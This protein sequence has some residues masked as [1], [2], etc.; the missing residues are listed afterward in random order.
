MSSQLA[1]QICQ[2]SSQ[3]FFFV[4]VYPVTGLWHEVNQDTGK[5]AQI[6]LC[7][8]TKN[9][10][11]L[12]KHET[13]S[14]KIGKQSP[15]LLCLASIPKQDQSFLNHG[16]T[17]SSLLSHL[18][19]MFRPPKQVCRKICYS[20]EWSCAMTTRHCY[21][22]I[23]CSDADHAYSKHLK[24]TLLRIRNPIIF[25]WAMPSRKNTQETSLVEALESYTLLN[26]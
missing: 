13:K 20:H 22:F 14:Y 11:V 1:K 9:W 7:C 15:E 21:I 26:K 5:V 24:T 10:L 12:W 8:H 19:E 16:R 25:S 3:Y 2:V 17:V 18:P 23:Y 4:C 6:F